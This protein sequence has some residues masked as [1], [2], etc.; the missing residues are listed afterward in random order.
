MKMLPLK[1]TSKQMDALIMA[2]NHVAAG[3]EGSIL[4]AY[5]SSR[6]GA[7]AER[8]SEILAMYRIAHRV[9]GLDSKRA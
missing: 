3:G 7:T 1:L 6:V 2:V 4:A 8:A 9:T 5:G